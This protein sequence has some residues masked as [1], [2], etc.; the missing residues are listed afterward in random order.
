[1]TDN[2]LNPKYVIFS[3][4]NGSDRFFNKTSAIESVS[5]PRI[6]DI[7]SMTDDFKTTQ[8]LIVN[9]LREHVKKYGTL[10]ELI[11]TGH[12]KTQKIFSGDKKF[13]IRT[14]V[15]I[16][17][18]EN[19][20]KEIGQKVTDR[21]VFDGCLTFS[22][23]NEKQISF[24]REFADKHN[25]E[26]VGAT[27]LETAVSDPFELIK[28]RAGRFLQF[29]PSGSIIRDKLDT[30]YNPLALGEDD[31]SWIDQYLEKPQENSQKLNTQKSE[32]TGQI[33][34]SIVSEF[35]KIVKSLS[36]IG[37]IDY[38]EESIKTIKPEI[39]ST[40]KAKLHR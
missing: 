31:R 37:N 17:A 15:I 6:Y 23:L 34:K 28:I 26:I 18:I 2:S 7:E 24:Y 33:T 12:G 9:T 13:Q 40:E 8:D 11:I 38:F 4:V 35:Y 19:L 5:N 22:N 1:M 20:E 16:N 39:F 29:S 3:L 25:I 14:D 27:S 32:V 10:N 30:R 21:I 36:L